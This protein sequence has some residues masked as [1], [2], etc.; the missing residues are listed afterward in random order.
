MDYAHK[1]T[2]KEILRL[3]QRM[4]KEYR[5]AYKECKEKFEKR[6]KDFNKLDKQKLK[7][8]EKGIFSHK[9]YIA[10]RKKSVLI[11]KRY[12]DMVKSMAH[13]YLNA[14]KNAVKIINGKLPDIYA[15][16]HNYST[17]MIERQ[18]RVNT[19]YTLYDRDTVSRLFRDKA[20]YTKAGVKVASFMK[21]NSRRINSVITQGILQGKS[22]PD[23]AKD[24]QKV[25][26]M[27][28]KQAV[29]TARTMVTG[30]QNAGRQDSYERAEEMGIELQ[31][32]WVSTLDDRTRDTHV[33]LDGEIV[34]VDST[35]SNGLMGPGDEST[36]DPSE[37][38][39]CRCTTV[40]VIDGVEYDDAE[41]FSRID[42]YEAWKEEAR[43]RLEEKLERAM[44]L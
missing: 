29:R 17:Y 26:D 44:G 23:I 34:D 40:S 22:I 3:E 11:N 42:D 32:M 6:M 18:A 19:S 12:K 24:L 9:D 20:P 7:E 30:A 35:F 31:K 14:N 27:N 16:N 25:A 36:G 4:K 28:Y 8:V 15:M 41:R 43:N 1:E 21:W 33:L 10:W 38:M 39:N 2:D 5:Q 13:D 37:Y